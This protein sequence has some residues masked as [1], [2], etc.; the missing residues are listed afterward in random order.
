MQKL[1]EN[2][3]VDQIGEEEAQSNDRE[4]VG[5]SEGER[6]K[7]GSLKT[8]QQET[9]ESH[10]QGINSIGQNTPY[11]YDVCGAATMR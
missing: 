4:R 9:Q 11:G 1:K 2:H 3:K 6:G 10:K 5:K 7:K 8:R